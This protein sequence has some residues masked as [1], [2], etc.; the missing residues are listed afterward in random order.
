MCLLASCLSV[1]NIQLI[2]HLNVLFTFSLTLFSS[3]FVVTRLFCG[4]LCEFL[5][6]YV[7]VCCLLFAVCCLLFAVCCLLFA[8]VIFNNCLCCREYNIGGRWGSQQI[9]QNGI[10]IG[11]GIGI[12]VGVQ[13]QDKVA[14]RLKCKTHNPYHQYK[15]IMIHH[16]CRWSHWL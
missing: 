10:G 4:I 15:H 3:H 14:L 6:L 5:V 7:F 16:N 11:I 9:K 13:E 2:L 1:Y 8:D 12:G